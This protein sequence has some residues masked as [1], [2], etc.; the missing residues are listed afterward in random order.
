MIEWIRSHHSYS[1]GRRL[2][3]WVGILLV[4]NT[5]DQCARMGIAYWTKSS[6]WR[7]PFVKQTN[8]TAVITCMTWQNFFSMKQQNRPVSAGDPKFKPSSIRFQIYTKPTHISIFMGT[9]GS[10]DAF[11]RKKDAYGEQMYLVLIPVLVCVN[12]ASPLIF[13]R[14]WKY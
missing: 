14:M 4:P 9:F 6:L 8:Q 2:F 10:V 1:Q 7:K 3:I 13:N 5:A 11:A 12:L